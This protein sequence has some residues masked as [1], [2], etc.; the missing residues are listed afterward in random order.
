V[1]AASQTVTPELPVILT[2]AREKDLSRL[3]A[4][5]AV[6]GLFFMLVPGTFLGAMNLIGISQGN[7]ASFTQAWMQAHGHAQ[8]FGWIGSFIIGIGFY[9]IPRATSAGKFAVS[10][11]WLC[12]VLWTLGVTL[13]WA[14][15]LEGA[16]WRVT[17][18]LGAVLEF[19]A[20][21]IFFW[22]ISGHESSAPGKRLDK[23][24]F[25]VIAG[26]LGF[27]A[28]LCLNVA[29]AVMQ[30]I[31]GISAA[32]PPVPNSRILTLATWGFLV[33]FV[34][35]FSARWLPTFLGLRPVNDSL[36]LRGVAGAIVGVI[37]SAAG[38]VEL[39]MTVVALAAIAACLSLNI[40]SASV[41]PPKI[42]G[43][44]PTFPTFVRFAYGWLLISAALSLT[45]AFFDQHHGWWGAS[46]HAITVG[47]V[48]TM[49][50]A[51][52]Q[53]VLPAFAGMK[54]LYSSKL[55]FASLL[56]LQ[57]G[58]ALRVSGQAVA[59]EGISQFAWQVLPY[60]AV[61]EMTAVSLFAVNMLLTLFSKAEK[62]VR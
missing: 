48:S 58:C 51:I 21:A 13:R 50:L 45:A 27:A 14:S 41:R 2:V 52:G 22:T 10:R 39:A 47:F 55:M 15:G 1:S 11:G 36:L 20:F 3:V 24:I 54:V 53:R 17:L 44:H 9:S 32:V 59:Y 7:A 33:P 42:L 57:V 40:F 19:I 49:V 28:L 61:L 23:W 5:Y 30:S 29:Y 43:V 34:W 4:A 12:W 18:P 8:I 46:R 25:V 62:S 60:S 56:L 16:P 26:T 35:G 6:T 37:L 31:R 38:Y